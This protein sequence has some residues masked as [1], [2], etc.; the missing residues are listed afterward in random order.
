MTNKCIF[1]ILLFFSLSGIT[2]FSQIECFNPDP[3]ELTFVSVLDETGTVELRWTPSDSL[4]VV[5]YIVHSWDT[6]NRNPGYYPVDTLWNPELTSF[7][8]RNVKTTIY[9]VSHVISALR[10]PDCESALSN[11]ISTI[12]CSSEL[13]SCRNEIRISWSRY[14]DHPRPV[15]AYQILLSKDDGPLNEY[16]IADPETDNITIADFETDSHYCFRIRA[17]LEPGF[18]SG[19]NETCVFTSI[20][21]LPEWINADYA[22]INNDNDIE[23]S[24]TPDPETEIISLQIEKKTD[25]TGTYQ[26][27]TQLTPSSGSYIYT[28]TD[29]D[30]HKINYYRAYIYNLCNEPAVYSNTASNMVLKAETVN[31]DLFLKWNQYLEWEGIVDRYEV[32]NLTPYGWTLF[33]SIGPEDT[34]TVITGN[35]L[36]ELMKNSPDN[37][38]S[39]YIRAVESNNPYTA[40]AESQSST[41]SIPVEERITVPTV[42][43]PDNN[44]L[45]DY[46]HP[47]LSFTPA[48]YHLL[49]TD[50]NRQTLF[51]TRDYEDVWDG[52]SGG[53]ILPSG[54]YLWFLK[55]TTP[56][57]KKTS[58]SG[59]V[60]IFY[61]R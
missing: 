46:F 41:I 38:I 19:S 53:N 61:Q 50:L 21:K 2:A 30:I 58:E 17:L 28:D 12:Y 14:N 32:Y 8:Y 27:L 1:T 42:F 23:L 16:Y 26:W 51:E 18:F 57:G 54:V 25:N 60:T 24:F 29:A 45:N 15:T 52:T 55:T 43:T 5:A 59:T 31:S 36:V 56:S 7:T 40:S 3:P 35:D 22:T 9:S 20:R 37:E 10:L 44:G 49:I 34:S 6:I 39:F 47:V 4:D 13:D 48:E 11:S 33:R